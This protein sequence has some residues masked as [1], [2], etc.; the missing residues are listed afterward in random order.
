MAKQTFKVNVDLDSKSLSKLK[1]T[2][3]DARVKV[4]EKSISSLEDS[5]ASLEAELDRNSEHLNVLTDAIANMGGGSGGRPSDLMGGSGAVGGGSAG[6]LGEI[7]DLL[8][9]NGVRLKSL[10]ESTEAGFNEAAHKRLKQ[11]SIAQMTLDDQ[12]KTKRIW[13]RAIVGGSGSSGGIMKILSAA[14]GGIFGK[15][16]DMAQDQFKFQGAKGNMDMKSPTF[17]SQTEEQKK[18]QAGGIQGKFE[19]VSK[20]AETKFGK[21]LGKVG[22]GKGMKAAGAIGLGALGLAALAKKGFQ[23]LVESSPMLKQMMKMLNFGV[24]M[25]LRP[26]G[27]FFGFFLRPIFIMLLRKFIIPFYQTYL[28]MM[29][30]MGHDMGERVVKLL[31]WI[32]DVFGGKA[33]DLGVT[34][35]GALVS[36]ETQQ[37]Q[38]AAQ[39]LAAAAGISDQDA[40]VKLLQQVE[41]DVDPDNAK[42]QTEI[43]K[44]GQHTTS[45]T[46][47][48]DTTAGFDPS[49]LKTGAAVMT[50]EQKALFEEAGIEVEKLTDGLDAATKDL[51]IIGSNGIEMDAEPIMSATDFIREKSVYDKTSGSRQHSSAQTVN[52]T[53]QG[54][55]DKEAA[56]E[57]TRQMKQIADEA[58]ETS[59]NKGNRKGGNN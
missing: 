21:I 54:N 52:I 15:I 45:P 48:V 31:T 37:A 13:L 55:M 41:K 50:P 27:D 23:A 33:E 4:D 11:M 46:D 5:M 2:L 26:I 56:E 59:Y 49:G 39:K 24:M 7:R 10:A 51:K 12:F 6:V 29:Q 19:D 47:T 53:V 16:S 44:A 57:T 1:K 3:A 28:P 25:I 42:F 43:S 34:G 38:L 22:G 32:L 17:G 14:G 20:R 8:E 58:V 9:A 30:Q 40:I 35:T 36:E 18:E